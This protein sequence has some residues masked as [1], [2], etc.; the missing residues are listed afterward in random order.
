MTDQPE[1][2]TAPPPPPPA[3]PRVTV[4]GPAIFMIV[5]A[6]IG[7]A[8]CLLSLF[9]NIFSTGLVAMVSD[10][11]QEQ[12]FNLMSGGVGIFIYII[13]LGVAGF[14]VYGALQMKDLK[15]HAMAMVA[16]IISM[17]PCVSPCCLVGLP[18]GIWA[19]VTLN[20]PE[21]K[22]AFAKK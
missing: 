9:L 22:A 8:F 17:I 1:G 14:I 16:A 21:V 5:A 11:S 3:D 6:A 12:A 19:L 15:N 20:K 7:A 18:A 4:Q 13:E 10:N 2:M